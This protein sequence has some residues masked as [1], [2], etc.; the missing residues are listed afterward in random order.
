MAY[1]KYLDCIK[2]PFSKHIGAMATASVGSRCSHLS[3]KLA[4]IITPCIL[5]GTPRKYTQ[6]QQ[7]KQADCR[8]HQQCCFLQLDRLSLEMFFLNQ[9][10]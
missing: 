2:K 9:D 8:C 4:A 10:T 6:S 3:I 7:M 1:I 5:G